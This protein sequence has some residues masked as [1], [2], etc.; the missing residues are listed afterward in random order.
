[1]YVRRVQIRSSRATIQ[2]SFLSYQVEHTF[3]WDPA[4]LG[5]VFCLIGGKTWLDC[6]LWG[7]VWTLTPEFECSKKHNNSLEPKYKTSKSS[8]AFFYSN[9]GSN[10]TLLRSTRRTQCDQGCRNFQKA[11]TKASWQSLIYRQ[12]FIKLVQISTVAQPQP[13]LQKCELC[14]HV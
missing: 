7:P 3:T 10:Y 4:W 2:P 8:C 12:R 13:P 6:D 11:P 1:M 5:S 9:K 14:L